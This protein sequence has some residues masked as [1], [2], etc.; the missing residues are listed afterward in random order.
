M[1]SF[2]LRLKEHLSEIDRKLSNT[3]KPR[4]MGMHASS[5]HKKDLVLT[6]FQDNQLIWYNYDRKSAKL[7]KGN[8]S[9]KRVFL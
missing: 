8:I 6:D 3:N 2:S 9:R 4:Y 5:N 7:V 1:P